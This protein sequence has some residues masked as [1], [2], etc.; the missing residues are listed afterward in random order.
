MSKL[1]SVNTVFWSDPFIEDLDV[2]EKLLYLYLITNEKTNMLG[3]YEASIK[4]MSFETGIEMK[5]LGTILNRFEAL[6]KVKYINNYVMLVNYMKHQKYNTNMKKAA[7]TTYLELP[8]KLKDSELKLDESNPSK[9]FETLS[10][11]YGTVRKIEVEVEDKIEVENEVKNEIESEREKNASDDACAPAEIYPTFDDFW[12]V[13]DKKVGKKEKIKKKW[14][15]LS[16]AVKEKII[17]HVELYKKAEPEKKYRKNPE[18]YLNN[19]SWNDEIIQSEG[20]NTN[21]PTDYNRFFSDNMEKIKN[22]PNHIAHH[23]NL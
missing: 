22:D 14:N 11:H 15:R 16:Q 3:I 20:R 13:Y 17:W 21:Q 19:E 6:R 12:D 23:I 2:D 7:I 8:N 10:N 1:R 5:R 18:T 9:A 4:K